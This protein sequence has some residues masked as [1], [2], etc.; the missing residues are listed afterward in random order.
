MLNIAALIQA[1]TA[2]IIAKTQD[3]VVEP[4]SSLLGE[5]LVNDSSDVS[6]YNKEKTA[7]TSV[8]VVKSEHPLFS[9]LK[10]FSV[11]TIKTEILTKVVTKLELTESIEIMSVRY[12]GQMKIDNSTTKAYIIRLK[13]FLNGKDEKQAVDDVTFEEPNFDGMPVISIMDDQAWGK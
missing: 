4:L 2:A 10:E 9:K 3:S 11:E 5:N 7:F 6:T 8:T 12:D 13:Y 1:N